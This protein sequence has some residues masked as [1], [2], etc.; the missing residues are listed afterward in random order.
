MSKNYVEIAP[1]FDPENIDYK[2]LETFTRDYDIVDGKGRYLHWSQLK[3][4]LPREN[5]QNIWFAIKLKRQFIA[6]FISIVDERH[7]PFHFV[8]SDQI[9]AKLY[10]IDKV[11]RGKD[12]HEQ[13][14]ARLDHYQHPFLM[15]SLMMEEAITSAQLEGAATTRAVAKKMLEDARKP[16]NQDEQMILNNYCLLRFVESVKNEPLTVDLIAEF[17]RI[18]TEGTQENDVEPGKFRQ[19]NDIYVADK[20]GDVA[21]QPPCFSH[22]VPRLEQL[23]VFA[24]QDHTCLDVKPFIPT[25]LKAIILH[26]ML[27]YEHPF[28][29]GNGRTARALFYWYLLK[30]GYHLFRYVSISKLLRADPVGYGLSYLYTERDQNDMTYFIDFQL[31]IILAAFDELN[32]YLKHKSQGLQKIESLLRC[33]RYSDLNVIQKDIIKKALHHPGRVFS[34]RSIVNLYDISENT[35]RTYLNKLARFKLLLETKEGKAVRYVAPSDLRE[36]LML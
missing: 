12:Y 34:V 11:M 6:K 17:H 4:R 31:D 2:G 16:S 3:W 1:F 5:A 24:N 36:R 35:A 20:N 27:G 13:S 28:R 26:F 19:A 21:H 7:I 30:Q 33:S 8:I 29:D 32:H 14:Q 25:L 18:T 9:S 15:S 10:H 23:C 22:I